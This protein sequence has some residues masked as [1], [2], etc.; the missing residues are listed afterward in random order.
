VNVNEKLNRNRQTPGDGTNVLGVIALH[1]V[2]EI[3]VNIMV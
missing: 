2:T 1:V 3:S